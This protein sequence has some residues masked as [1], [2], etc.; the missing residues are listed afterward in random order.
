M[1]VTRDLLERLPKTELHVHLDGSLRPETMIELAEEYGVELPTS[2]PVE[3]TQLMNADSSR[4]LE[5]YLAKFD[6]TLSLLQ[7]TDALDRVAFELAED[8]AQE[9][10]R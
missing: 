10:V 2:D 5:E 9:N 4:N 1:T 6:L 7:H 8:N 3:L